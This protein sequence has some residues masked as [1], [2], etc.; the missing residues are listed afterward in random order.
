M[1][2]AIGWVDLSPAATR[3]LKHAL[4]VEPTGIVD[5]LGL[6]RIHSAYAERFFPGTSVLQTRA[7]YL[8]FVPWIYLTLAGRRAVDATNVR[9]RKQALELQLTSVLRNTG[10]GVFGSRIYPE[11]PAQSPDAA[12]WTALRAYGVV[13]V[14]RTWQLAAWDGRRIVRK[15]DV[16]P[17]REEDV[18]RQEDVVFDVPRPPDDWL[19]TATLRLAREEAEW[20]RERFRRAG[21][22]LLDQLADALR[23][24]KRPLS[25]SALWE[26]RFVAEVVTSNGWD[27]LMLRARAAAFLAQV[28]RA[29]YGVHVAQ[30]R[31]RD[32][33]PGDDVCEHYRA[34]ALELLETGAIEEAERTD[35]AALVADGAQLTTPIQSLL[36]HV[37]S[38]LRGLRSRSALEDRLFGSKTLLAVTAAELDRKRTRA[39]L[40]SGGSSRR[41][42][43]QVGTV[44]VA[45]S[46]VTLSLC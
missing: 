4:E 44:N 39:R 46:S 30:Q 41:A 35:V 23:A 19:E 22:A 8:L 5:E 17:R 28:V 42:D 7:K 3:K 32:G 9:R 45:G 15:Q 1:T 2:S 31:A 29:L 38:R 13:D 27:A 36:E 25:D 16:R 11:P 18:T 20:V 21:P 33:R 34:A 40:G 12:Y 26:D 24:Q 10:G 43:F 14:D 6:L 37:V